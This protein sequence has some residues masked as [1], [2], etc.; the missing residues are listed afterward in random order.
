MKALLLTLKGTLRSWGNIS[1]GDDRSTGR[2][3]TASAILGLTGACMGV[4][5][6]NQEQV[7]AWN[8]GFYVCTLSAIS[9]KHKYRSGYNSKHYPAIFSDYHTVKNSINMN[10]D[11]RKETIVSHRD[12]LTDALDVAAIIPAH[13]EANKWLEQLAFAIQQPCFTPYL[14]RR[15]N[16]FSRPLAEPG[17]KISTPQSIEELCSHLLD[18]LT[19]LQI[20]KWIP[21]D[22]ILRIPL[23]L[24]PVAGT[25]ANKWNFI[26][27][28]MIADHRPGSLR[29]FTNRTVYVYKN[30]QEV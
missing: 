18:R 25:F 9:Y 3:P 5:E 13:K 30:I 21:S 24:Q 15:S 16:P 19:N 12:Y 27:K 4:D 1:V 23:Q 11:Q 10:G 2:Y 7:K 8:K 6:H 20:D 22:C 28:E 14:G 29:F 17:E 26:D